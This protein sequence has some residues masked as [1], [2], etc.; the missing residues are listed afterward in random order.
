LELSKQAVEIIEFEPAQNFGL[1][2][3]FKWPF[4]EK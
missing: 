2:K 1:F 3:V 4:K